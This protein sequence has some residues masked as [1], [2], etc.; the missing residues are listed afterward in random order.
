M[1]QVRKKYIEYLEDYM[2]IYNKYM[3][4]WNQLCVLKDQTYLQLY[5]GEYEAALETC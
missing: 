1:H 4:E 5:S 3:Q 2:P